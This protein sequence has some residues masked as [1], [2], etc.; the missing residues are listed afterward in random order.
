MKLVNR[1]T[2]KA[3]EKSVRKA[4]K[5]HGPALIAGLVSGL[6]STIATLGSTEAPDKPGKSNL[7]DVVDQAK[8]SLTGSKK[9]RAHVEKKRVRRMAGREE[10]T[11]PLVS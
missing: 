6:A 10:R 5:Q 1:K 2:K 8:A 4:M 7:A 3:I 9:S 11:Q